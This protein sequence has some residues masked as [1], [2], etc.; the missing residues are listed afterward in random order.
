MG[1][2]N[3]SISE[4]IRKIGKSLA[5]T[6][7]NICFHWLAQVSRYWFF[8]VFLEKKKNK[9]FTFCCLAIEFYQNRTKK[10]AGNIKCCIFLLHPLLDLTLMLNK[11]NSFHTQS[12]FHIF[13][14]RSCLLCHDD[15]MNH[16]L[17][18]AFFLSSFFLKKKKR[19]FENFIVLMAL[20]EKSICKMIFN[21]N[22]CICSLLWKQWL[23]VI[24]SVWEI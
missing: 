6:I 10:K 2:G 24:Q 17:I 5:I 7:K 11:A 4:I 23:P 16:N 3:E 19:L 18:F 15:T 1:A 8:S 22:S 21:V 13:W 9:S 12:I 20:W 14:H